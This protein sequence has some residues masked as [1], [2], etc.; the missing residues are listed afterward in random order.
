MANTYEAERK[1]AKADIEADGCAGH[2]LNRSTLVKSSC[3][4]LILS[5][6]FLERLGGSVLEGDGKFMVPSLGIPNIDPELHDFVIDK[7]DIR[8]AASVG[9]Y[10]IVNPNPFMPGG[11]PIY[12]EMHVRRR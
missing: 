6:T 5:F 10:Q 7:P 12:Y 11:V 9:I 8:Y 3:S 2:I 4:A 1:S